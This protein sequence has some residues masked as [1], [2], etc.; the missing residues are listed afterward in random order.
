MVPPTYKGLRVL[1]WCLNKASPALLI[2]NPKPFWPMHL[3]VDTDAGVDD[4]LAILMALHAFPGEQVVGIT[5]VF[6]NVDVHQ[7]NHNVAHIL[8]AAG[9]SKIPVYSGASKAIVASVSEAK[10]AGH[11]PDGLGGESGKTEAPL[12]APR[13]NEAVHA[14]ID[15]AHKYSGELVIA[16]V[17][18][19]TNIALAMLLDPN[20]TTNVKQFVVMG[21]LSR[22]EGNHTPHAE[23]NVC[24]DPEATDIV[25]QHCSA[26]KLYVVPFETC[27]DNAVPWDTFDRIFHE[28]VNS[29]GETKA[30]FHATPMP[31]PSSCIQSTSRMLLH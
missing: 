6:G 15:L 25:Y 12:T 11:G 29:N 17:G 28:E 5:T 31:S 8:Q 20:F 26:K 1:D 9:R 19:L 24:C 22:G 23:F 14:L 4:A 30:S 27:L 3:L 13:R 10:W 21:G 2:L 7:A 16:A 18:P